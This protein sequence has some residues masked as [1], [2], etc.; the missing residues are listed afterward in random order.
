LT[1]PL[2]ENPGMQPL[3]LRFGFLLL[4]SLALVPA[5]R[6]TPPLDQVPDYQVR[7]RVST[8]E[9]KPPSADHKFKLTL[10]TATN[11]VDFAGA[12]WS[13][14]LG[15][16]R[17]GVTKALAAYPNSYNHCWNVV[18][19]CTVS[20]GD[21][22]FLPLGLEVETSIPD[23]ET[24]KTPA[25]LSGPNLGVILWKGDDGNIHVDTLTGHGRRVYDKAMRDAIL[26]VPERPRKI[27]FGDRFIGGDS[28][29]IHWKEGVE[30]LCGI[31]FNAHYT[32]PEG[33]DAMLR[34]AGI[35]KI[36]GAIYNP[37]GYAFNFD[38]NRQKIFDDFAQ[39]QVAP[40]LKGGW[41]KE[42]IGFWVTS[43][44]PGW[45]YPSVYRD[46]NT[47]TFARAA[48]HD[49]LRAQKL[50]PS[51]FGKTKWEDINLIGRREYKDLPSRRLFYW[52]N[53]FVP[54]ASSK[55]FGEA[56][57]AYERA[58]Y[59]DVPV[60]V[61][62]NN[63]IGALYEPGP[64]ANNPD[65]K[66]P[67]AAMGQH[68]WL[69]F[70]R[71]RGI[72]CIA[73][74]DWF[75]DDLAYQW[76]M[77][78]SKMRSAAE[79]GNVGFG[80][81]VIPRVGGQRPEGMSQKLLALIGHG[82]KVIQFFVFGPEYS[83]P[84]NCYSE[85]PRVFKPLS[86]AMRLTAKAEDLLYP[87]K[88]KPS[89]VA[90]LTPQSSQLWD[91]EDEDLPHLMDATNNSMYN[92]RMAYMSE[93]CSLF[94]A[95]QHQ[96][97]PVQFVDEERLTEKSLAEIKV[98]YVTAPDLPVEAVKR[99]LEWVDDGGTL[100]TTAGT[101]LFDRYH[102]PYDG[103]TKAAGIAIEKPVRPLMANLNAPAK[104]GEWKAGEGSLPVFG[105]REAVKVKDAKSLVEFTD[106]S[107]A[108]TERKVGGGRILRFACFPGLSYRRSAAGVTNGLPSGF[109][110]DWRKLIV[111]PVTD[112]G[113]KFPVTLSQSL[114]EAPALYSKDGVAV[115]LLNWSGELQKQVAL[116]ILADRKVSKVESAR[117]GILNFQQQPE[118]K[119]IAVT[120]TLDVGEVDVLMLRY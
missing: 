33:I 120:T 46:F 45:Y 14:W 18:T 49:Y 15:S 27:L 44:E 13:P 19:G 99:L 59:P 42:E 10:S 104:S 8:I 58:I 5:A 36:Y 118:A 86:E 76:S 17:D 70:G 98:L 101:G 71:V 95:L 38:P 100:V 97:I 81:L 67:N 78:A 91:L 50:E 111:T 77:Y 55:F 9:G 69:E 29:L 105:D 93:T 22:K 6:S 110:A 26:P 87:G 114:I 85:N 119:Q 7:V 3:L 21:G 30:R 37:P 116:R 65:K 113:L 94:L 96:S 57:R 56:C 51:S 109:S 79:L 31:G 108:L 1:R 52:S 53:R 28:D 25:N 74:E 2:R 72:T 64:V 89:P 47:N 54:W 24:N 112:A 60:I 102:Q 63:F 34:E 48:F 73:T 107:P 90:I 41:K 23:K 43:D 35:T 83:F 117:R 16:T 62:F 4:L 11:A 32:V 68:D 115:T 92:G 88:A 103:L 84:G 106:G 39:Q 40:A 82:A 20:P 12:D 66:D 75:G 61:N 80:A